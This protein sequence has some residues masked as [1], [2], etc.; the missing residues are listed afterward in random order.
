MY[1][2][3][4]INKKYIYYKHVYCILPSYLNINIVNAT[5][6]VEHLSNRFC[7]SIK[8]LLYIY[9]TTFIHQIH[10]FLTHMFLQRID[11]RVFT[12]HMF[13]QRIDVRVFTTYM[14]DGKKF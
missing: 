2:L 3:I 12:T 10:V 14:Y 9:Q 6:Y 11:V 13:F 1:R 8:Q 7:T 4:Y 5:L